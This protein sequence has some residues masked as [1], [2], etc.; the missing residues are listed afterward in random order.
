MQPGFLGQRY[1]WV[2]SDSQ[3]QKVRIEGNP[4]MGQ[5]TNPPVIYTPTLWTLPDGLPH[6]ISTFVTATAGLGSGDK[7]LQA[8]FIN[9]TN[10]SF[11]GEN[12]PALT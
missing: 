8:G 12:P 5:I 10:S 4:T 9:A 6:S 1:R 7:Q 11:N 3:N 2:D